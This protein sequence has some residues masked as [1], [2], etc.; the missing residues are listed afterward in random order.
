MD[1]PHSDES[2]REEVPKR[3]FEDIRLGFVDNVA[4]EQTQVRSRS[5]EGKDDGK[6]IAMLKNDGEFNEDS[7]RFYRDF[8]LSVDRFENS[9]HFKELKA[10]YPEVFEDN[11]YK[12]AVDRVSNTAMFENGLRVWKH[13]E[14][15]AKKEFDD[16]TY[17]AI[18]WSYGMRLGDDYVDKLLTREIVRESK[19]LKKITAQQEVY[20]K[21]SKKVEWSNRGDGLTKAIKE[22]RGD[23]NK[24]IRKNVPVMFVGM[25][26][27]PEGKGVV[28]TIL[29]KNDDLQFSMFGGRV[30][31]SFDYQSLKNMGDAK[32]VETMTEWVER[33]AK[34]VK[35]SKETFIGDD[36]VARPSGGFME[37][38]KYYVAL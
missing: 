15:E 12:G 6:I 33:V 11:L 18:I 35:R 4:I 19:R 34:T 37:M 5:F 10:S 30:S 38:E 17:K 3:K 7:N 8:S 14:A 23:R 25:P 21:Y 22:V 16:D 9:D 24:H 26:G 20:K 36:K 2:S 31:Y 1:A 29:R 27:V 28:M 32:L 13:N